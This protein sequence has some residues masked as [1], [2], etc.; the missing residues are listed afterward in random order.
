[1]KLA[2]GS[3][4]DGQNLDQAIPKR[5]RLMSPPTTRPAIIRTGANAAPLVSRVRSDP[6]DT[7]GRDPFDDEAVSPI[8]TA[9]YDQS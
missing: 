2:K 6:L 1:M 5:R 4:P 9:P 7:S 3:N 8:G